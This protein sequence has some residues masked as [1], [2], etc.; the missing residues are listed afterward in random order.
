MYQCLYMVLSKY[1]FKS[2]LIQHFI[3]FQA[4]LCVSAYSANWSEHDRISRLNFRNQFIKLFA[5]S[6]YFV[7]V[8]TSLMTT[9][10]REYA[11]MFRCC[12]SMFFLIVDML[13][14]SIVLSRVSCLYHY[15]TYSSSVLIAET[16]D[17][18]AF[19]QRC[20][21]TPGNCRVRGLRRCHRYHKLKCCRRITLEFYR[22]A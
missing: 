22:H 14:P 12:L 20:T 13:K 8:K 2:R 5:P 16:C 11:F 3:E 4:F 9:D 17:L 1:K 21:S 10:L 6:L 15:S 19:Y 7:P 18:C